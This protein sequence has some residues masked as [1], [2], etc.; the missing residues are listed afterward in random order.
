MKTLPS[1]IE[2]ES[3]RIPPATHGRRVW[4]RVGTLLDGT[5]REP[6]NDAHLVYDAE[7]IHHVGNSNALPPSNLLNAGQSE[8]DA[9]LPDWTLLPGLIEAHAHFFLEGG[10]LD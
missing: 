4:L 10:E 7:A 9:E 2:E 1:S 3:L 8:P 5:S 6:L